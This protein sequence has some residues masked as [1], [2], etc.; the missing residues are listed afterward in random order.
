MRLF[1]WLS[2]CST[3]WNLSS[4]KSRL[5]GSIL[6]GAYPVVNDFSSKTLHKTGIYMVNRHLHLLIKVIAR[7]HTKDK[8]LREILI[9]HM[10][11]ADK[12][13]WYQYYLASLQYNCLEKL[14]S[15]TM[16]LLFLCMAQKEIGLIDI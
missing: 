13:V 11:K 16:P 12:K 1:C 7:S 6:S 15:L 9:N 5:R 8:A 2:N 4:K 14:D 10:K 3:Y